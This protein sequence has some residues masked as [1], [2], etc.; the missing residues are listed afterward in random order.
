MLQRT[1]KNDGRWVG[2][3][4]SN[5][6][7]GSAFPKRLSISS[8][9]VV[10]GDKPGVN[11][12]ARVYYDSEASSKSEDQLYYHMH[13]DVL[14]GLGN[15]LLLHE[16]LSLALDQAN[17]TGALGA[18]LVMDF[19]DFRGI[20]E[21]L[22]HSSGDQILVL[23][24]ERLKASVRQSDYAVRLGRDEFALI[25][26]NLANLSDVAHVAENL[27]DRFQEPF[28]LGENNIHTDIRL[29]ISLF[30]NDG[31]DP[32]SILMHAETAKSQLRQSRSMGYQFFS[33]K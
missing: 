11:Y 25:F 20:N 2:E 3:I 9:S 23:A 4:W 16:Q 24:S 29:G 31:N 7:D 8:I 33:R 1:L 12:Y 28:C 27:L 22:G 10:P 13:Y 26:N 32:D 6:K 17:R 15:R 18:L 21:A 14:T 30:P 5:R 19:V